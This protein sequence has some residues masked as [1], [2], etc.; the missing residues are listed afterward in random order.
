MLMRILL[1]DDEQPMVELLTTFL[2]P[3]A[4]YIESTGDLQ[5]ALKAAH[6]RKFNVII[7]DLR[8]KTTG[9]EEAFDAIRD[10]KRNDA[11]VVVVSG[12]PDPHLKEDA[13]AA[14]ADCFVPKDGDFGSRAMLIATHIATLKL[15]PGSY[16]SD[17]YLQHVEM[18]H[19]MVH[20]K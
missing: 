6:E 1:V 14:G 8:L 7:L 12:L 3:I 13:L 18:L 2:T 17:S 4:S 11:S 19:K 20:E 10:F 5:S 9:K 15:P 16:K